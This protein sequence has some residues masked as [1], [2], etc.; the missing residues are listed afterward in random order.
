[1]TGNIFRQENLHSVA[2]VNFESFLYFFRNYSAKAI[3][4][5]TDEYV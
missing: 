3:D 1:M 4:L 2:T 5:V